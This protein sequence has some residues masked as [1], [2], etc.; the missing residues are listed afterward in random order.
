MKLI[1]DL[2]FTILLLRS[3]NA[4]IIAFVIIDIL[5][6]RVL[7]HWCVNSTFAVTILSALLNDF[8]L[9]TSTSAF[10]PLIKVPPIAA[11]ACISPLLGLLSFLWS[12]SAVA[13]S[14]L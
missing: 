6:S 5:F 4:G 13:L 12:Q 3:S 8:A 1:S 14:C 7:S 10:I 2:C 11:P 9:F